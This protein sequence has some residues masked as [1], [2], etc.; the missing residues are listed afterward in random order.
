MLKTTFVYDV[1]ITLNDGKEMNCLLLSKPD[2]LTLATIAE[3]ASV[4]DELTE[5]MSFVRD[6]SVPD[7]PQADSNITEITVAGT[8]VG[9]VSVVP[10]PAYLVTPKRGR[11]P[12]PPT[13]A[14]DA[15]DAQAGTPPVAVG[16]PPVA[17]GVGTLKPLGGRHAGPGPGL[18]SLS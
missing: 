16:T 2:A 14:T 11:K 17:V 13:D 7:T 1:T 8:L 5:A 12:K 18:R 3:A 6:L 15:T 4:A 10:L 9:T